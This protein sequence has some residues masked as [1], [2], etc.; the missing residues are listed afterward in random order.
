MQRLI[1]VNEHPRRPMMRVTEPRHYAT[2]IIGLLGAWTIVLLARAIVQDHVPSYTSTANTLV[3]SWGAICLARPWSA[4]I[5]GFSATTSISAAVNTPLLDAQNLHCDSTS[6]GPHPY[7]L[8]ICPRQ[9]QSVARRS[10]V[11]RLG[12]TELL[13]MQDPSPYRSGWHCTC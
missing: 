3:R 13:E 10:P 8:T 4:A 2:R 6:C 11:R 9:G 1:V 12:M 5:S 7:M